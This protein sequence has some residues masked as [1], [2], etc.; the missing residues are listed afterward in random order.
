MIREKRNRISFCRGDSRVKF[1]HVWMVSE[2]S[3][4]GMVNARD[5]Q[6]FLLNSLFDGCGLDAPVYYVPFSLASNSPL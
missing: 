2:K 1:S 6:N 3:R 5:I 4:M